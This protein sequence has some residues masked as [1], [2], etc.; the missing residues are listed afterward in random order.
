MVA[1][2][3]GVKKLPAG[4]RYISNHAKYFSTAGRRH[5]ILI[6]F[7]RNGAPPCCKVGRHFKQANKTDH[8]VTNKRHYTKPG[9]PARYP[10]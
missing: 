5:K 4:R 8:E 7:H 10:R 6:Q 2:F 1:G 3:L 9:K